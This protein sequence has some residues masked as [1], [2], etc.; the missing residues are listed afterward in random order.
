MRKT[1]AVVLTAM[2]VVAFVVFQ[3]CDW[4]DTGSTSFN[5]SRGGGVD[6]NFSGYYRPKSGGYLYSTNVTHFVMTQMGNSLEVFD[7]NGSYYTGTIGTPGVLARPA[8]PSGIYPAGAVMLQA[9]ISFSGRNAATGLDMQFVG[10][11]HAVAVDQVNGNDVTTG[12]TVDTSENFSIDTVDTSFPGTTVTLG[13]SSNIATTVQTD[14]TTTF[15][16][17]E[18]NTQYALDGNWIEGGAV[19]GVAAIAPATMSTFSSISNTTTNTP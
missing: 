2:L 14:V 13:N 17:T 6:V 5:T 11:I 18:S 12:S 8:F 16:I 9:Q 7:S 10:I 19:L 15:Q 1:V 3:G 4:E